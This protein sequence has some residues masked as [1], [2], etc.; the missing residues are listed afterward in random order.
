MS[1]H[2]HQQPAHSTVATVLDA[3][4]SW[5][6]K[7]RQAVGLRAELTHCGADEVARIAHDLGMSSEEFVS[8][9]S[10]GQHAADQLARLLRAL[11]V[12]PDKLASDEP[13]TMR[14]LQQICI[15]CSHKSQ[16]E[17]DLAAGTA[18]ERYRDYC[19]NALS[20]AQLFDAK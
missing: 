17:H 15:T 4:A 12:D 20:L 13:A 18:A 19:P 11:G 10:K 3:I 7:Y 5:V 1:E 9:A 2:A 16:C 8:L 14:A 6:E